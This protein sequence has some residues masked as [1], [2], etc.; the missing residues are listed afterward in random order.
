LVAPSESSACRSSTATGSVLPLCH[1]PLPRLCGFPA[2][3]S[4]G[5]IQ[6]AQLHP[7]LAFHLPLESCPA[8]P[9]SQGAPHKLLSWTLAPF[10]TSRHGGPLCAGFPSPAM[11]R[12]QG[13]I[14]LLAA[15][16]LRA[17]AGL[18]SCQRRSWDS[19]FGAFPSWKVSGAS[20][21]ECTHVPLASPLFP[22]PE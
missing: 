12:L 6:Y 3:S 17:L 11:F 18:I 8:V 19:P 22:P 10:S 20:P 16:S 2:A 14:T 4:A 9:S 13:L 5:R 21:P 15:C 7:L 1:R